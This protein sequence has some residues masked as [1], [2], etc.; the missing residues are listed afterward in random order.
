MG[1]W[2]TFTEE[3]VRQAIA[4]ALSMSNGGGGSLIHQAS[5]T[6]NNGQIIALHTTPITIVGP[7]GS[8]RMVDFQHALLSADTASGSYGG[9]DADA[10]IYLDQGNHQVSSVVADDGGAA[11]NLSAL[12]GSSSSGTAIAH[13][14]RGDWSY[15]AASWSTPNS[16]TSERNTYEDAALSLVSSNSVNFNG[17][18]ANNSL[19]LLIEFRVFD[20]TLKKYLTTD[21]SGWNETTRTF[22]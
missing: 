16:T 14:I 3:E 7:P 12:I 19:V 10:A 18:H 2:T 6:L 20:F 22:A 11:G 1:W 5:R 8:G 4:N 13:A 21:E 9:F 17:G 15:N